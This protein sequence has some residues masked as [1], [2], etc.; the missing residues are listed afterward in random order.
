ML[1]RKLSAPIVAALLL[2]LTS[3]NLNSAFAQEMP[4]LYGV[5]PQRGNLGTEVNLLLSGDGFYNLGELS[6]VQ[7]SGQEIPVLDYAVVSNELIRVLIFIPEQTATG[8]TEISFL[9]ENMGLHAYFVVEGD[10][11]EFSPF[12]RR[13]SPQDGQVDTE[14]T[15]LVEGLRLFELGD[16]GGVIIADFEIPVIDYNIESERL[17]FISVYIPPETPI[18]E[19]EIRLFFENGSFEDYFLVRG[20]DFVGPEAPFLERLTPQEGFVDTDV[21]LFLEGGGFFELGDLIGV[22]I[23]GVDIPILDYAIASNESMV[24]VVYLPPELPTGETGIGF[25]FDNYG[26]EDF[27]FIEG[28]VSGPREPNLWGLDPHEGEVDTEIE[29]F[30]EGEN[31][32]ELGDLFNVSVSGIDIPIVDYTIESNESMVVVVHLPP[33][34]PTGETGIGFFFDNYGFEDFF[35]IE[36][37]VSGPREPNLWGLDPQEGEV[38]TE[39]ELFLEGENLFGVGDLIGVNLSGIDIPVLDYAIESNDTMVMRVYLPEDAPRGE[40]VITIFFENAGLE[41]SFFVSVPPE[42]PVPPAVV[43]VVV[44]VLVG[45]SG[46]LV[47]RVLRG[48]RIPKEKPDEKSPQPEAKIDFIVAVDPGMQTVELSERSLTMDI[49]MRFEL[50]V[51]PGE[52]S[53]EPDGNSL[54]EG[55]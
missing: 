31:L 53:V 20:P 42:F 34:L 37:R 25:F 24:V 50:E 17:M 54:I 27:F 32:F 29:L 35:F 21:E 48:R 4:L 46:V 33:E 51:D 36:G 40:Q 23:A 7:I 13:I 6:R 52:Q 8:E 26:F 28:R 1:R 11:Q 41:E 14:M 9:F 30:L 38:D 2:L 16:L 18:G 15:L 47:G 3:L 43:V 12:I 49:N 44:V 19:T 5:Y 10:E 45:I 55:E 39:I 22:A